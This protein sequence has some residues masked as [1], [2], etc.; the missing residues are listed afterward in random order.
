MKDYSYVFN[1]HPT[2]IDKMYEKYALDANSVE[3]GWK[4]FFQGFE[5]GNVSEIENGAAANGLSGAAIPQT[6][7]NKEFSVLS[8]IEGFRRRGHLVSTTNPIRTRRD[9]EPHLDITDYNLTDADL[10]ATFVAGSV[11][12]MGESKLKDIIAKC[13]TIYAGNIGFE[14]AHIEN[15]EKR[16]WLEEKI[17]KRNLDSSYGHDIK[18]KKRI[19]EKLNGAVMFEKFLHT[20]YVGQKR[21]SLEGGESTIAALDAIINKGASDQVEE[22]IIGMAHRGRLNVLANVMGKTYEHIFNEFEGAA[23]PDQSFG[24]GDVKYHLGY[25]SQVETIDNKKIHL[26]LVPNPSHLEAVD[27]VVE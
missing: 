2:F 10:E 20:K 1:A 15:R 7:L 23:I 26:K 4:V 14:Y 17:E 12:G 16:T 22:V 21:F 19:L 13:T 6:Q 18:K 11:L 8:I 9:H 24:D 3:E 5:F 25:S 27:R